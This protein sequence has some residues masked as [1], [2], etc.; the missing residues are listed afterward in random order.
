[1]S[2]HN[3]CKLN[4]PL[5]CCSPFESKSIFV[6]GGGGDMGPKTGV[7]NVVELL[8]LEQNRNEVVANPSLSIS[9]DK[10]CAWNIDAHRSRS[11]VAFGYGGE[12]HV[13]HIKKNLPKK[14]LENNQAGNRKNSQKTETDPTRVSNNIYQRQAILQTDSKKFQKGVKFSPDGLKLACCGS[15]GSLSVWDIH[16]PK[17]PLWSRSPYKEEVQCIDWSPDGKWIASAS[18]DGMA[19]L[20]NAENGNIETELHTLLLLHTGDDR[21]RF[22]AIKFIPGDSPDHFGIVS[23]HEP[24]RQTKPPLPCVVRGWRINRGDKNLKLATPIM[25]YEIMQKISSLAVSDCGQ[26]IG[27]GCHNGDVQCLSSRKLNLIQ[28]REAVHDQTVTAC[29]FLPTLPERTPAMFSV[30]YD[31]TVRLIPIIGDSSITTTHIILIIFLLIC[32][33]LCFF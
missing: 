9:L 10:T 11:L 23:G 25:K 32:L 3:L 6:G 33:I 29:C 12:C 21:Y 5:Y 26:Y 7:P 24:R 31:N 18:R 14:N 19:Y 4:Y 17:A 2:V 13:Y 30:S 28:R 22:R 1:M 8:E 15:D 27:I 16:N 20:H